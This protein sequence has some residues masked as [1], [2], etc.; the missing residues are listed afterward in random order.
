MSAK[1]AQWGSSPALAHEEQDGGLYAG[2]QADAA[3]GAGGGGGHGSVL[4][5]PAPPLLAD[6]QAGADD[7]QCDGDADFG[8]RGFRLVQRPLYLAPLVSQYYRA[9]DGYEYD[10]CG[11]RG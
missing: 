6:D 9:E 7:Q 3:V 11:D 2:A 5:G 8:R 4:W 10:C 1:M